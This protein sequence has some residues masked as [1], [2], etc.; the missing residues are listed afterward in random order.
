MDLG[1]DVAAECA[2]GGSD[3]IIS[4]DG[5]RIA[6][7][8]RGHL[9]TRK[10]DQPAA[11]ELTV[12]SGATSPFFSPDSQWIGFVAGGKVRKISVEGGAEISLCDAASSYTGAAGARTATLSR[13][14]RV[15]WWTVTRFLHWRHSRPPV[16]LSFEGDERT[17]RW[18]QVLPGAKAVLFTAE[19]LHYRL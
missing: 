13:G 17:H 14:L 6:Y 10:L 12:T 2:L 11:T 9:F 7:L 16:R 1:R 5:T 8:S 19:N 18:P 3:V 4:P 15:S